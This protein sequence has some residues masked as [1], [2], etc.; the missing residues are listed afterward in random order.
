MKF[1]DA[2]NPT[3]E[4]LTEWAFTEGATYP[5]EISQDWDLVIT[6]FDRADLFI[7][8]ANDLDC[9]KR[10]FFL[11]CLYLL[12]GDCERTE[13]GKRNIP[14]AKALLANIN[15][16]LVDDLALWQQRSLDLLDKRIKF[17]YQ[18]WCLGGLA[19]RDD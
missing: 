9:P 16:T 13:A 17:N 7:R 11:A 4:E 1:K 15:V 3:D 18:K 8:L 10:K 2:F 6:D 5:D 19:Y 12:I 14:Q